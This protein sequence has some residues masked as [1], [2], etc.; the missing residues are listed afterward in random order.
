VAFSKP[1]VV[2]SADFVRVRDLPVRGEDSYP[3]NLTDEMTRL[4]KQPNAYVGADSLPL[5]LKDVQA[6][7]L[8]DLGTHGHGFFPLR[9]GSGKTLIGFLAPR[10]LE[11]R[12]PLLLVPGGLLEK[13]TRD[14][15]EAAKYWRVAKH[16]SIRSYDFISRVSGAAYLDR[17]QH[18]M[19]ILDEC[20]K[21]KN[22]RAAVTRRIRRYIEGRNARK[23]RCIVIPMSGTIMKKS[24]K[25]F[26][27][28]LE[29]SHGESAPVPHYA[30]T[31]M[32]WSEALDENVNPF[33]Q[34]PPGVLTELLPGA[35]PYEQV[36]DDDRHLAR[37][38]YQKRLIATAGVIVADAVQDYDGSLQISSIEYQPNEVTETNFRKLR[39][40]SRRP[41]GFALTEAVQVWACARQLALGMHYEWD[42]PAPED[43]L[44]KRAQWASFVRETLKAPSSVRAGID[45]ELQV[46][47]A[48]D[49]G[50]V[51]DEYGLLAHWRE[52]KPSFDVNSKEVWHDDTALKVCEEWLKAHKKGICWVEHTLFGKELSRRTALPFFGA[53]GLDSKGAYIDDATGPII[54][55]YANLAGRN[56]QFKWSSSLITAPRGDSEFFEQLIGRTHR[57]GQEDDEVT[58]EVLVGCREHLEAIPRALNSSDVKKS[59]LGFSQK[60]HL[61]DIDWPASTGRSGKRWAA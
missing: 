11:A 6:R 28:L 53:G 40:D 48:V 47:N 20:H 23:D 55:S 21:T 50:D 56:L 4:L 1:A 57:Q 49:R 32:E 27:H 43:W 36:F 17:E 5:R 52:V 18:D 54:A 58:V 42:P 2:S 34:R 14:W 39:D 37:T 38:V 61:A 13:T 35:V 26:A 45:S 3:D 51:T 25:D 24:I 29:W 10:V 44:D 16:L 7:A 31:L 22:L 41:D 59:L 8:Y 33:A 19:L 12:R 30:A 9:V 15:H 60:L 46:T